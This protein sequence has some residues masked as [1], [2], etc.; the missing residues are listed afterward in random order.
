MRSFKP[1]MNIEEALGYLRQ[2]EG[3][4]VSDVTPIDMGELSKVYSYTKNGRDLV[5]HFKN[6]PETLKKVKFISDQFASCG[7]PMPR[8]FEV[9]TCGGAHYSIA[10]KVAGTPIVAQAGP[11]IRGVL[12]D[13]VRQFTRMNQIRVE[14]CSGFGW[15]RPSGEGSA[16]TWAEFLASTFDV[17]QE[18]FY[19]GWTSLF[20][21][22]FLE[23]DVFD[24]IYA[25]MMERIGYAP[26]ERYLVHGDFHFG[27]MLSQNHAV[28]GI[29][30]WEMAMYGDFMFDLAVLHVWAPIAQFP[31]RVREAWAEEGR[32]IPYF[33]ER[34]LGYQLFKGL[35]GLRFY[36]KKG[37]R[38]AYD[39]MKNHLFDLLEQA[40]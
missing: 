4:G 31:Q 23:K 37:D 33:E 32:S 18:G 10:E 36:A 12:P 7:V 9:G 40:E 17:E 3:E 15:I 1:E 24:R 13:L 29:V 14:P 25:A 5:I 20:E 6:D 2:I 21:S 11:D 28:T 35:D 39:F 16:K 38:P 19:H 27:N 30:D 8:I 26:K 34:L 22:S